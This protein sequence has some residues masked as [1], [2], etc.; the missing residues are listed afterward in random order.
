V[1]ER[2]GHRVRPRHEFQAPEQHRSDDRDADRGADAPRGAEDP[3]TAALV[4]GFDTERPDMRGSAD[5]HNRLAEHTDRT[6]RRFTFVT[7]L[8]RQRRSVM[9][10]SVTA[11]HL[12]VAEPA[13]SRARPASRRVP[14]AQGRPL[15]AGRPQRAAASET[16]STNAPG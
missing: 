7:Q 5:Q 4:S 9:E 2:A 1:G 6:S 3:G 15:T 11:L 8:I 12:S 10:G 16:S 14:P 13:P